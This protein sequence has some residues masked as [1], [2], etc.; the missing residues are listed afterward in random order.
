MSQF[1]QSAI[2]GGQR[3]AV[4]KRDLFSR[5]F[6]SLPHV[7]KKKIIHRQSRQRK[8]RGVF[9]FYSNKCLGKKSKHKRRRSY[10]AGARGR[11]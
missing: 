10:R 7:Q 1:N 11:L 8:S 3:I 4:L 9:L 2:I 5:I 6:L